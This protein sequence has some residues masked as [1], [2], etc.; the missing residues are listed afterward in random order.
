MTGALDEPAV[1]LALLTSVVEAVHAA[2]G[3]VAVHCQTAEG[4]R[5]AV[6]AGADSLE[7]GMHLDPALLDR[8]AAQ[9][10]AFVPTLSLRR[11]GGRDAGT[12]AERA[13]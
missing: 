13:P 9:G 4:T 1:P 10:T 7:H 12:G 5:N 8:M 3:K 6:L 2:G 11:E